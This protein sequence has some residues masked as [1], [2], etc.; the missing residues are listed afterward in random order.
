M[1]NQSH[2]SK[3]E[4]KS[5]DSFQTK[6]V[7]L[8]E[9]LLKNVKYIL[10]GLAP[11]A[12]IILIFVGWQ[13]VSGLR[14]EE[15]LQELGK[16]EMGFNTERQAADKQKD[17]VRKQID[18]LESAAKT[19]AG[20]KP[21][22]EALK[23]FE[24][25][26]ATKTKK[27]ALEKQVTEIKP[28]HTKSLASFKEFFAKHPK[29]VE[30]WNSGLRAATILSEALKFDEAIPVVEQIA[31]AA[32]KD[33][34]Y[35]TQSRIFL[36]GLLEEKAE[37][38]KALAE[39]TALE[40]NASEDLKPALLLTKGRLLFLKNSKEEAKA[41]FSILIEKFASSA[42]AQKARSLKGLLN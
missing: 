25:D 24:L 6:L 34:F 21:G 15:R 11:I 27:E 3:K 18:E 40:A 32:A 26:A 4:L 19:A 28:D 41:T 38:D 30:G 42:E 14:S 12:G 9:W 20:I 23:K 8:L 31:A 2:L 5:M 17:V 29:E 37:Y 33:A 16:I 7:G 10:Y 13:Y 35:G 22:E 1:Q 36:A 39:I